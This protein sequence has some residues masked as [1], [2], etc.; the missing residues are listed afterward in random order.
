MSTKSVLNK[1]SRKKRDTMTS[2]SNTSSTG[3]YQALFPNGPLVVRGDSNSATLWCATARNLAR[4]GGL[5]TITDVG[6]RT[7][8]TCYMRG[9]SEHLRIQ[10]N[11]AV[12]WIHRRICFTLKGDRFDSPYTGDTNVASPYIDIGGTG[13]Q[14]SWQNLSVIGASGLYT[15]ITNWVFRGT[16]G[17]DW[18]DVMTGPIDTARVTL[19][20]DRVRTYQS[21][22]QNGFVRSI[23]LWHPMNKNL[24]YD[25][26]E[27]GE[28]N[29]TRYLSVESKA[30]MGDY[31]VLDFFAPGGTRTASD[32]LTVQ[33][34]STLYWHEK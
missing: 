23:K 16:A 28:S 3:A 21:G 24:V 5:N 9:V 31:Y 30:G 13:M 34:D 10:T 2:V 1:T 20:Y 6:A 15:A 19:K 25:D 8:S 27:N 7:S 12:P 4:D 26:D 32:L 29:S 17:K 33:T 14:R 11:S 22:N 18:T